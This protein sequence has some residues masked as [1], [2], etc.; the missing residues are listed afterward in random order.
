LIQNFW[1]VTTVLMV[2]TGALFGASWK[3]FSNLDD[4]RTKYRGDADSL[5]AILV[6][7]ELLP[8]FIAFSAQLDQVKK[9]DPNGGIEKVLE[10]QES[11]RAIKQILQVTRKIVGVEAIVQHILEDCNKCGY[12]FL[13]LASIPIVTIV[14]NYFEFP[15]FLYYATSAALIIFIIKVIADFTKYRKG[16]RQ[17]IVKESE[18]RENW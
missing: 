15:L 4:N 16:I 7:N 5:R 2:A 10:R 9:A 18:I 17:L 11:S 14:L 6:S 8:L 12:D 1:E 3:L 13:L